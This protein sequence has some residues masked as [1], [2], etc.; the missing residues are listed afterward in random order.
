VIKKLVRKLNDRGDKDD[1]IE[2]NEERHVEEKNMMKNLHEKDERELSHL[3][4]STEFKIIDADNGQ[5]II[6]EKEIELGDDIDDEV[7]D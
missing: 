1:V 5:C 6:R 7:G 3:I 4:D 2:E